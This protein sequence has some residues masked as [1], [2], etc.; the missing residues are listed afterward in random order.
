MV[1][2]ACLGHHRRTD[3]MEELLALAPWD[4]IH[5]DANKQDR[6]IRQVWLLREDD[7]NWETSSVLKTFRKERCLGC[8]YAGTLPA[9]SDD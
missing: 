2:L 6:I 1:Y 4:M 7:R 8:V 9:A 5:A 3:V